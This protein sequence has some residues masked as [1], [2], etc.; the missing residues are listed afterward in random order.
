[1]TSSTRS[2]RA[3]VTPLFA[4]PRPAPQVEIVVPVRD[5]AATLERSIDRLRAFLVDELP[6][7]LAR[8]DRRQ[9]LARRDPRDRP[10]PGRD[11]RRRRGPP[12]RAPRPRPGAAHGVDAQRRRRPRLHGRRP[13]DRP[14]RAAAAARPARLRPLG[15]LD[16]DPAGPRR[17][18]R[19]RAQARADLALVQRLA[20]RGPERPLLRRAVRLQG[21][22][23]PMCCASCCPTVRDEAWFFDTEL[24][25][26]AQRR[27]LRV[28]EVPVDWVDDPDSRV[29]IVPTALADLRGVG[30]LLALEP[31]RALRADRR[32][33]HAGLRADLPGAARFPRRRRRERRRADGHG[34]RQH[35]REPPPDLRPARA[36][37][38]RARPRRRLRRLRPHARADERR[39]RRPA[40]SRRHA[41]HAASSS[42]CS[43]PRAPARRSPATWRCARWS[44]AAL[45]PTSSADSSSSAASAA[46]SPNARAAGSA[47]GS[48]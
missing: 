31:D 20:A 22:A 6:V 34:G 14:A 44:S 43:S 18:G 47:S 23:A 10:P 21:R 13:V 45:R 28:H 2:D 41:D 9:R 48:A 1:M 15:P 29:K 17:P 27:G 36:P 35:G 8:H 12:P 33:Q 24:L 7:H 40:P 25:V 37:R 16:R 3:G 32:D 30:R 39:A 19:P 26:Q 11:R 5:E 42:P 38:A 4:V 46:I